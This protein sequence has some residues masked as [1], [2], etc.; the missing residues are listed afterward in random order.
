[1]NEL[2][3]QNGNGDSR[4]TLLIADDDAAVRSALSSQ[5][6]GNF[7]VVA[8]AVDAT[9]AIELAAEH[10]PNVALLDVQMPGGG[11]RQAV[12]QIVTR[13][14]ETCML[15]LSGDESDSSLRE[16][17]GAG[18]MAYIRKGTTPSEITQTMTD[19]LDATGVQ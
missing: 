5:L 8:I 9:E 11:A 12:P 19:A 6:G 13:S 3:E 17:L 18:A 10:R 7:R 14:P 15:L 1:M 16:L 4:P 2:T